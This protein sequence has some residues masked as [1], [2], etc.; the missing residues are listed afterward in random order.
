MG[1]GDLRM[2]EIPVPE[3]EP[4]ELLVRVK[5]VG[6]CG[7][8]VH[9]YDGS[10]GRRIPP[11]I[12]GHEASGIVE[13]VG[14]ECRT[15]SIGDRITFDSTIYCGACSYCNRGEINFCVN[16]R[17]LGVS[18]DEYRRDG[19]FAQYVVVPERIS[20]RLSD[21]V[22]FHHASMIEPMAIALHALEISPYSIGKTG[23]VIGAGVIGLLLIQMLRTA[24]LGT[25]IAA[26]IA[27]DRLETAKQIGADRIIN[28]AVDDVGARVFELTGGYGADLAFDAVGNTASL[29]SC[30]YSVRKGGSVTLIGNITPDVELPLQ[31]VVS[32]Q[33]RLQGSNA[34][35]GEYTV[36]IDLIERGA[37]ELD[38]LVSTVAPLSR[39]GELIERLHT[40]EK[41]LIKVILEP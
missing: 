9:G 8:D 1:Y 26:D 38:P 29:H 34:S 6:I 36:C 15:F 27:E 28:P 12:M 21:A 5:A 2:V 41:G 20:Y 14:D 24:G 11:V 39:G 25:I 3:A 37:V 16:R 32:R 10:T 31:Y 13:A 33:I 23:V 17:V 19:A 35:A 30:I 18:C 22:S 4:D 40:G 7:S